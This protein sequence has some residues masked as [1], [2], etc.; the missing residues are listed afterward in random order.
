MDEYYKASGLEFVA[1]ENWKRASDNLESAEQGLA[2][3]AEEK[4]DI[5]A[6]LEEAKYELDRANNRQEYEERRAIYDEIKTRMDNINEKE[7]IAQ[8]AYD[9]LSGDIQGLLAEYEAKTEQRE[10]WADEIQQKA[11]ITVDNYDPRDGP[12]ML[13][14]EE[15]STD[16]EDENNQNQGQI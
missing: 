8:E 4:P 12:P 13:P 5:E 14:E 2:E 1:Y 9:S 7:R 11:N 10:H 16:A 6:H 3:V 15:E